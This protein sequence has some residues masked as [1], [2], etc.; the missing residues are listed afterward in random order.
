MPDRFPPSP[1]SV[2]IESPVLGLFIFTEQGVWTNP[3]VRQKSRSDFWTSRRSCGG[4]ERSGGRAAVPGR[5]QSHP[6]RHFFLKHFRDL[7]HPPVFYWQN[8]CQIPGT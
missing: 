5:E 8:Y 1:P 6:L 7:S 3:L 4:P 2:N